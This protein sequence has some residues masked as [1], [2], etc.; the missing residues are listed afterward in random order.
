MSLKNHLQQMGISQ[1]VV[2]SLSAIA[3]SI[4]LMSTLLGLAFMQATRLF[5][6]I[7]NSQIPTVTSTFSLVQQNEKIEKVTFEIITS[8]N[9]YIRQSLLQELLQRYEAWQMLLT[10]MN[11]EDITTWK[12]QIAADMAN[13][14][15]NKL[16]LA[17]RVT[18]LVQLNDIAAEIRMRLRVL[19]VRLNSLTVENENEALHFSAFIQQEN[20][21]ISTLLALETAT[22]TASKTLEKDL[23]YAFGKSTAFIAKLPPPLQTQVTPL[24]N[25]ISRFLTG[26]LSLF[27]NAKARAVLQKELD[28]GLVKNTFLT[29]KI[30]GSTNAMLAKSQAHMSDEVTALDKKLD[31]YQGLLFTLCTTCLLLAIAMMWYLRRSVVGRL[32]RLNSATLYL[33]QQDHPSDTQPVRVEGKDEIGRLACSV[34]TLLSEISQREEALRNSH[35]LLEE[36]VET[37]TTQL[38]RKNIAL[39][40]EIIERRAVQEAL[41]ESQTRLHFLSARLLETQEDER[42]RIAAELHDDIGPFLVSIKF[43]M[44]ALSR[45][46]SCPENLQQTLNTLIDMVN[47]VADKLDTIRLALRPSMLDDLGFIESLDWYVNEFS[48]IHQHIKVR[49]A[50]YASEANIPAKLKIV[51]FR[52]TQEALTN[53]A[54]YSEA[55][56]VDISVVS[57]ATELC[58]TISDNG[59]G[60]DQSLL[61]KSYKKIGRGFGLVSMRERVENTDGDFYLTT[62]PGM[63]TTIIACWK[64]AEPLILQK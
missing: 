62:S 7:T 34:N 29:S 60:F 36:K 39:G 38:R 12:Q 27:A 11:D 19:A 58:L 13:A 18:K 44:E 55:S 5:S 21:I 64:D 35:S 54:K 59:K 22:S 48:E 31:G 57:E 53:V 25:E 6:N 4:L 56:E 20:I 46:E 8:P 2:L 10:N 37:R 49:T 42:R 50:I 61:Q 63:G 28:R 51:L 26:A 14:Y 3:V 32:L 30:S 1:R 9:N 17:S 16:V 47:T 41:E 43:G 15:E 23:A 33:A 24:H 52:V 45:K 40:N